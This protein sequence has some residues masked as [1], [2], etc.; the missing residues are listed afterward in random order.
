M[1]TEASKHGYAVA[2][3]LDPGGLISEGS[4]QNPFLVADGE[5]VT[6]ILDASLTRPHCKLCF[7]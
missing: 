4:G 3:G 5:V 6:P 2:I 7:T 1:V